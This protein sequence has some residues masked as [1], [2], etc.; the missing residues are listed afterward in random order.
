MKFNFAI[1]RFKDV[2]RRCNTID[3]RDFSIRRIQEIL[4][5]NGHSIKFDKFNFKEKKSNTRQL[6]KRNL[7]IL[8]LP[9]LNE[10]SWRRIKN[11]LRKYD[12][13]IH[14]VF[15]KR[16]TIH[17][18]FKP[19][20]NNQCEMNCYICEQLPNNFNCRTRF[21]VYSLTCKLCTETK[22]QYI[23]K[24]SIWI[25]D[26]INQHKTSITNKN[27][28]SAPSIHLMEKHT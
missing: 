8:K 20:D 4:I 11:T 18:I 9:Y 23:G 28:K 26:R 22:N 15:E 10:N 1:N 13:N 24:T 6:K 2:I 17:K 14:L 5:K 3:A 25:K 19:L 7:P 16:N 27:L 21:V 12:I